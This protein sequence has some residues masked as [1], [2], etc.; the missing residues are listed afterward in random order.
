MAVHD[1]LLLIN[2]KDSCSMTMVEWLHSCD[3]EFE[4]QG[5]SLDRMS[6]EEW[7]MLLNDILEGIPSF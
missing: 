6:T 2:E 7:E 3:Q 4:S 5:N 1:R